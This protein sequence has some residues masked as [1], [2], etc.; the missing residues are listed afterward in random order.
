MRRAGPDGAPMPKPLRLAVASAAAILSVTGARAQTP[1][2]AST[3]DFVVAA[4]QSDHFEIVEGRTALAQTH[5]ARVRAFAQQMI[6]AHTR[7]SQTLQA[8]AL[9]AGVPVSSESL[10]GDQ[11]KMLSALQSQRGPEFDRTYLKQQSVA[12]GEALVVQQAYAAEGANADVRQAAASAVPVIQRHLRMAKQLL[13][14]TH[15]D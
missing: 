9:K 14:E 2:V 1:M 6:Q 7:T 3:K 15:N 12:H 10:N 11:Q 4:G 8:A 5:D 13:S